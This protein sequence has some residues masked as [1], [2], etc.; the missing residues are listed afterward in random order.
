VTGGKM[1]EVVESLVHGERVKANVEEVNRLLQMNKSPESASQRKKVLGSL[2]R[3]QQELS[4]NFVQLDNN[5]NFVNADEEQ[6]VGN[7][8]AQTQKNLSRQYRS[9]AKNVQDQL[10]DLQ[11]QMDRASSELEAQERRQM[12]D[13]YNFMGNRWRAGNLH[14]EKAAEA[15]ETAGDVPL[16]RLQHVRPFNGFSGARLPAPAVTPLDAQPQRLRP[17]PAWRTDADRQTLATHAGAELRVPVRGTLYTFQT[18]EDRPELA[19]MVRSTESTWSW[20]ARGAL[21]V[22]LALGF[23]FR[24]RVAGS[25]PEDQ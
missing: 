21:L 18:G 10:K 8:L 25:S 6:R 15:K 7:K 2:Q 16:E 23:I 13:A 1:T 9:D 11:E 19:L 17:E 3:Q 20:S 5:L 4:D 12:L 22:L 24:K 14:K